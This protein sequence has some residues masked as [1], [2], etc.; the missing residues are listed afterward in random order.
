MMYDL[1]SSW[2]VTGESVAGSDGQVVV[3]VKDVREGGIQ[4]S[5]GER[6]RR[7]RLDFEETGAREN[8]GNSIGGRG[9]MVSLVVEAFEGP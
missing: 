5:T 9:W 6:L 2:S 1:W 4:G 7:G 3:R 8:E